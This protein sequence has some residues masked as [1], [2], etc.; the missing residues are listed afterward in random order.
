MEVGDVAVEW[1]L[2]VLGGSE[3]EEEDEV[4][5]ME[6]LCLFHSEMKMVSG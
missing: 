1:T 6:I 5:K 3:E 4:G 2:G